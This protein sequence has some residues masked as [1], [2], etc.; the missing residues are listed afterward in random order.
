LE[1]LRGLLGSLV[2]L[3]ATD[4][5]PRACELELISRGGDLNLSLFAKRNGTG[6]LTVRYDDEKREITVD[7]SGLEKRFNVEQGEQRTRP[8]PKGLFHLRIFVDRSSV[9][10]FVNDGDAVF[11]TRVFPV[12]GEN[13]FLQE[14]DASVRVWHLKPAVEDDF[15]V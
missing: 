13:R 9:E 5:L 10:I 15:V 8:L 11:S 12:E 6:G 14:G 1:E 3:E 2:D 4:I 7:R